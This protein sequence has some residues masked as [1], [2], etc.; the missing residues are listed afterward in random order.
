M[1]IQSVI[2]VAS[3]FLM[4]ACQS[5]DQNVNDHNQFIDLNENRLANEENRF[6]YNGDVIELEEI[7][8]KDSTYIVQVNEKKKQDIFLRAKKVPNKM[9]L[10]NKGVPE[11]EIDQAVTASQKEVLYYFEFEDEFK[12]D[13]I[14]KHF[15]D[16]PDGHISYLSFDIYQDFYLI[17]KEGDTISAN[18]S[19]YERDFQMAPYERILLSFTGIEDTSG[20]ALLYDD[21]LF[22]SGSTVFHFASDKTLKNYKNPL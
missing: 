12:T 17:S 11:E 21:R 6:I 20:Y 2:V 1:N 10:L 16:D 7:N 19:V 4:I 8:T 3:I 18:Y 9:Y 14:A 5:E 15:E 22:G 13:L